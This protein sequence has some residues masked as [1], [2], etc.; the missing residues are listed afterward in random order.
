MSLV[1]VVHVFRVLFFRFFVVRFSSFVFHTL[2]SASTV[3]HERHAPC[4]AAASFSR[5]VRVPGWRV[6]QCPVAL[7]QPS[8][9]CLEDWL[10]RRVLLSSTGTWTQISFRLMPCL[11]TRRWA[12]MLV[13]VYW[14]CIQ[15]SF[16]LVSFFSRTSLCSCR[17]CLGRHEDA[18]EKDSLC[19]GRQ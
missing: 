13:G 12:C 6:K 9:R 1:F 17:P 16:S 11:R 15:T 18:Q 2:H 4:C 3:M 10:L 8:L 19:G 5:S 7:R 14:V